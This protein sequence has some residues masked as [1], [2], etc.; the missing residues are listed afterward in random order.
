MWTWGWVLKG[1]RCG[2]EHELIGSNALSHMISPLYRA[3]YDLSP[4][5]QHR[6]TNHVAIQHGEG[7]DV[8]MGVGVEGSHELMDCNFLPQLAGSC[9]YTLY[10]AQELY[11]LISR[12][13]V[14][15]RSERFHVYT[16]RVASTKICR[17][18]HGPCSANPM[19]SKW[20]NKEDRLLRELVGSFDRGEGAGAFGRYSPSE[21]L[22][23]VW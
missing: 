15:G 6:A 16:C 17:D 3:R 10:Q 18:L 2:G 20:S 8:H 19:P 13:S 4:E 1:H 9:A 12:P 23:K 14:Q 22:G 11:Q 5:L 7:V 21:A